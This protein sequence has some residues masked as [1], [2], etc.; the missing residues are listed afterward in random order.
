MPPRLRGGGCGE[1]PA[2][3]APLRR[4]GRAQRADRTEHGEGEELPRPGQPGQPGRRAPSAPAR[5]AAAGRA[6]GRR[7]GAAGNSI[8]V[9]RAGSGRRHGVGDREQIDAHRTGSCAPSAADCTRRVPRNSPTVESRSVTTTR[10][11]A[12]DTDRVPSRDAAGRS[13]RGRTSGSRPIT[14]P[15]RSGTE[16]RSRDRR[17]P[18]DVRRSPPARRPRS[19]VSTA[20]V[21]NGGRPTTRCGS[22]RRRPHHSG[23]A[24]PA[25]SATAADT[26]PQVVPSGARTARSCSI[27]AAVRTVRSVRMAGSLGSRSDS[28][29]DHLGAGL[30]TVASAR[31]PVVHSRDRGRAACRRLRCLAS[32]VRQVSHGQCTSQRQ[33]RSHDRLPGH[34]GSARGDGRHGRTVSADVRAQ[35]E[36]L[37]GRLGRCS[38]PTGP[39]PR[40]RSSTRSTTSSTCT[41]GACPTPWTA[42]ASCS[43][44]PARPTPR[45]RRRSPRRSGDEPARTSATPARAL[46]PC[47][48]GAARDGRRGA[49]GALR[50][51]RRCARRCP[52][53]ASSRSRC[54][55]SSRSRASGPISRW[56]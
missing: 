8:S 1:R 6:L 10:S 46:A 45:P 2:A 51:P 12:T 41:R 18:R 22:S 36:H 47:R 25:A 26:A 7:A 43:P 16:A 55:G 52:S 21:T 31:H 11:P 27:P 19:T 56:A 14:R 54:C 30:W 13:G 9:A 24:P 38:A 23:R 42:S 29:F 34:P 39:A 44:G 37:R 33:D 40:P 50:A 53:S 4:P 35:H 5:R 49:R 28:S 48:H 3:R 17:R 32:G 20:P 15:S